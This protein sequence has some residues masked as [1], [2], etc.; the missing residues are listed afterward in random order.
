MLK[1][2][3][4][5]RTEQYVKQTN[6]GRQ[7]LFFEP[8]Q[9]TIFKMKEIE[10]ITS[11]GWSFPSFGIDQCQCIE[12]AFG[13]ATFNVSNLSPSDAGDDL[14]T[15]PLQEEGN[16][17][18]EDKTITSIWDE[19]YLDSIQVPVG[20]IIRAQAKKFKEA[21]NGL[22]QATWAQSNTWRLVEAV[23]LHIMAGK[24]IIFLFWI[25]SRF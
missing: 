24:C 1:F 23:G 5:Q 10:V 6:K 9:G 21:F 8:N 22:I 11:R 13:P 16:Y 3:I 4:G 14:R 18:I 7:K 17:E 12:A 20:P 25:L 2:N 19:V 15:N